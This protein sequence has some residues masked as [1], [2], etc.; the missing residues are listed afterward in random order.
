MINKFDFNAIIN[1][2][3]KCLSGCGN[4]CYEQR[5]TITSNEIKKIKEN[6]TNLSTYKYKSHYNSFLK[7]N[8][9][10]EEQHILTLKKYIQYINN[11]YIPYVFEE[12][13]D[14]II[15]RNYRIFSYPSTKRCIF[16]NPM[17]KKCLIYESRP[18][19]CKLYPISFKSNVDKIELIIDKDCLGLDV[20]KK[21]NLNEIINLYS[22]SY[23]DF[24]EDHMCHI[25]YKKNLINETYITKMINIELYNKLSEISSLHT[26]LDRK[27]LI[28]HFFR[29]KSIMDP[30][31]VI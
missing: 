2:K 4:C 8:N 17:N 14:N 26:F 10:L 31:R 28:N 27:K 6:L 1:K 24:K 12:N 23:Q 16:L 30:F 11:F 22:E 19:T 29:G 18:H 15:I 25:Q 3:F 20:G 5:V 21:Y 7:K 13:K 9:L